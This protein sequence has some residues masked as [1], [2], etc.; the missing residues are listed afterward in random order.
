VF[1]KL[2]TAVQADLF[3]LQIQREL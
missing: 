1:I 3:I 2:Y